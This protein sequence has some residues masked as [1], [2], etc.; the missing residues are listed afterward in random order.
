MARYKDV[1][2]DQDKFIPVSFH[3]QILPGT[4][5]Y[6]LSY[7]IDHELDLS[8]FDA[9]YRNDETG[10]PAFD[11]A[12]LLKIVI[13]A[14]SRGITSSRKIEQACRENI[15]FMALS[16]DTQP[17][18]TTI[19]DFIS[20]MDEQIVPLFRNVLM[21]CDELKL[22]GGDMFA[23][24]GCKLPGNASKSWS[25]TKWE[26]K[27]KKKKLEKAARA[28]LKRHRDSDA[29]PL[30]AEQAEREIQAT[31]VIK[32]KAKKIQR[33]LDDNDDKPGKSGKPKKSNITDNDSAKM[34]TSKGVIQG[35]DGVACV[36]A[37]HQV[38][39]H[40]EAFGEAQE[41]DLLQ[42]MIEQTRQ[43]FQAIRDQNIFKTTR[44]TADSGFY[45]TANVTH[46]YQN[47]IDGY[48]PDLGFRKRDPRFA[49]VERYRARAKKDKEAYY[50]KTHRHYTSPDFHYD[51]ATHT[52]IC[53]A[54]KRLHSNGRAS[55]LGGYEAL[56]F[57][58][59]KRDCLP[60]A[61]RERCFKDPDKTQTRQVAIFIG[62]SKQTPPSYLDLMK[63]KIDT[64]EGRYQYSRRMGIVEPVFA[65]ICSTLGLNRFSLRTKRKVDIQWKLYCMV[66]NLLKIHR[67]GE[68][69][70]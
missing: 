16:A 30:D 57:R 21:I 8:V 58:G 1:Y 63:Q 4:F 51:E 56:K 36:D 44:L 41:H 39:V 64:R 54:G 49:D 38:I 60:C 59:A 70:I 6:T 68:L 28:M 25:G 20:T 42:P 13:Y 31:Q 9:R 46:L 32:A 2:Y 50:G 55:N 3:K 19:A 34:K 5:E 37:R 47:G 24:D 17:H 69:G 15:V 61:H 29:K 12:V 11:P 67:Y 22:I 53:P 27:Q 7:L 40:G 43:H 48:L 26:L 14:Y 66:H 33:W 23:I 52:C 18:F 62:R 35:Y 10:A 45:N 65:N